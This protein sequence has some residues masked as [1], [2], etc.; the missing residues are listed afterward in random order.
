MEECKHD[1]TNSYSVNSQGT[2]DSVLECD[3]CGKREYQTNRQRPP[4]LRHI[5]T[6]RYKYLKELFKP[7]F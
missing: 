3:K 5:E 2:L 6:K 7:R 4:H 1:W